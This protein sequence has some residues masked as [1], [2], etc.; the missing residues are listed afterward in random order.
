MLM[1]EEHG[2]ESV[3]VVASIRYKVWEDAKMEVII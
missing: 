3:L 1:R 2:G